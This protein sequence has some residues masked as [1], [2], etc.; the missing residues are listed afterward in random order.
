MGLLESF[1]PYFLVLQG[2]ACPSEG[3]RRRL[4]SIDRLMFGRTMAK[5]PDIERGGMW[6]R[7][8]ERAAVLVGCCGGD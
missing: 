7:G 4:E 5:Q 1:C 2:D 6:I 3:I 8:L